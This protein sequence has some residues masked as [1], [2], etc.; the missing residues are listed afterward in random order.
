[1]KTKRFS[2]NVQ[3]MLCE[4]E[5][6][7]GVMS[8]CGTLRSLKY[9]IVPFLRQNIVLRVSPTL[10]SIIKYRWTCC[11]RRI[12]YCYSRTLGML[13]PTL[14]IRRAS[15]F[16][17]FGSFLDKSIVETIVKEREI[18]IT[19]EHRTSGKKQLVPQASW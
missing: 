19:V 1:M 3:C 2:H 14:H 13:Y 17:L 18:Y 6:W 16:F 7:E 5:E 12:L 4:A 8:C 11:Q 9:P 10:R 15:L